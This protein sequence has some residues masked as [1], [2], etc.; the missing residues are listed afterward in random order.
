MSVLGSSTMGER[1]PPDLGEVQASESE[2]HVLRCEDR[3][4]GPPAASLILVIVCIAVDRSSRCASRLVPRHGRIREHQPS[5][6]GIALGDWHGWL[7]HRIHSAARLV[8]GL[9]CLSQRIVAG[10][11]GQAAADRHRTKSDTSNRR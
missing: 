5:A 6:G 7:V 3:H 8:L 4:F 2:F 1:S 9:G 11:K 10:V